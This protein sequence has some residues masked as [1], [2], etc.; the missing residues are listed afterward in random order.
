MLKV[1]YLLFLVLAV[2]YVKKVLGTDSFKATEVVKPE[3]ATK[4][5]G[6]DVK[7]TV[8]TGEEIKEYSA[9]VRNVDSV[10]DFLRELRNKQGLYYEKDLY[11]YGAEIISVFDKE[12]D[13]GKKWAVMLGNADITNKI[14][15]EYL[16]DDAVFTLRQVAK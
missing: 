15:D 11:T 3:P 13:S 10:E 16:T 7:L 14:A 12:A 6:V 9:R 5:R 4:V 2:L 8:E 1:T